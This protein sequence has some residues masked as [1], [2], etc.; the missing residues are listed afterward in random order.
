[1]PPPSTTKTQISYIVAAHPDD[2]YA[3]WALIRQSAA[4][5]PVFCVLTRGEQ[6]SY[7]PAPGYQGGEDTHNSLL[8]ADKGTANCKTARINSIRNLL[9][10]TSSLMARLTARLILRRYVQ[11]CL[12]ME[13]SATAIFLHMRV[14][15]AHS[16]SST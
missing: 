8:P 10:Y 9:T 13:L 14:R 11:A 3:S 5:Y 1:M 6:S 12:V 2:E 4:N 15:S 7:C 16:S